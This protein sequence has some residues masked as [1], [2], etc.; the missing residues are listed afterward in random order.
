MTQEI[1]NEEAKIGEF[2]TEELE[3]LYKLDT[4]KETVDS[5]ESEFAGK[6]EEIEKDVTLFNKHK[7]ELETQNSELAQQIA[8][9]RQDLD[10]HYFSG[11]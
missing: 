4:E 3:V 1:A 10:A 11:L 9:L 6:I 8:T 2:E 7:A 5:I